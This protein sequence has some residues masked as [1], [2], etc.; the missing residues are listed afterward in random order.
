MKG[1]KTYI[2]IVAGTL[3]ILA[4]TW[5][6]DLMTDELFGTIGGLIVAWTG[7]SLRMAVK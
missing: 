6:P 5:K 4:K 3:L 2:G 7:V 1:Y